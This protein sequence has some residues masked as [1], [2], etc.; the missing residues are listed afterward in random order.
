MRFKFKLNFLILNISTF[1]TTNI[2]T[3]FSQ[4]NLYFINVSF[5]FDQK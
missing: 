3:T 1:Y 2:I 4:K 5:L